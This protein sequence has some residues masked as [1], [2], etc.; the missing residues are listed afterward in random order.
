[1]SSSRPNSD[2]A[3]AATPT[4]AETSWVSVRRCGSGAQS[5]RQSW[6]FAEGY[7]VTCVDQY[8]TILNPNVASAPVAITYSP[9]GGRVPVVKNITVPAN[10]RYTVIV[11]DPAEG[12]GRGQE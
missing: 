3:S 12:V 5:P 9:G 1:M 2:T 8:L 10:A 11:H 7:T 6:L 4:S